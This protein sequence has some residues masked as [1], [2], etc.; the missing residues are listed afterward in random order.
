[1]I[2]STVLLDASTTVLTRAL[3][4]CAGDDICAG[5]VFDSS[6]RAPALVVF[7]T[8]LANVKLFVVNSADQVIAC[9]AAEDVALETTVVNLTRGA[10]GT[11]TVTEVGEGAED[12]AHGELIVAE[13]SL[14]HVSMSI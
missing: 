4:G 10:T 13:S 2:A 1:M 5:I 6:L 14:V 7:L 11:E 8:R 3:L 12:A 9:V